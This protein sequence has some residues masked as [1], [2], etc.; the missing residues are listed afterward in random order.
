M[1]IATNGLRQQSRVQL[2]CHE[3]ANSA[4]DHWGAWPTE[5]DCGTA[6]M[7]SSEVAISL[8]QTYPDKEQ[9]DA[10]T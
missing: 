4:L 8:M 2:N 10:K 5:K 3:F 1:L 7:I 6:S 9:A